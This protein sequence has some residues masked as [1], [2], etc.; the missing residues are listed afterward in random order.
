MKHDRIGPRTSSPTIAPLVLG[1]LASAAVLGCGDDPTEPLADDAFPAGSYSLVLTPEAAP[2]PFLAG[3]WTNIFEADGT[4]TV[5][6]DGETAVFGTF[7]VSGDE[8]T[9]E[10]AGGP[11][12]C[13]PPVERGTYRWSVVDGGG[14]VFSPLAEGCVGRREVITAGTWTR[15]P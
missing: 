12:T 2:V 9:L 11:L 5:I 3:A 6:K 8:I 14:L 4:T 1:L 7:T 13:E 10:D 15:D